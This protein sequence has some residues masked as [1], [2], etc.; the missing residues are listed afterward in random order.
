MDDLLG[1]RSVGGVEDLA[2]EQRLDGL[3][4]HPGHGVGI[5][6]LHHAVTVWR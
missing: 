2:H 5:H 4:D 1:G 6:A 3:P